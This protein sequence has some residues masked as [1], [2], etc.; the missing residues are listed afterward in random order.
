MGLLETAVPTIVICTRDRER[1]T[2]FYRDALGLT[3]AYADSFASV[4]NSGGITLRVSSVTDFVPHGHTILG[5][6]VADVKQS[7]KAL[8]ANGVS[9]NTYPGFSQDDLGI[10]TLPSGTQ[11][12]WFN[13][14]D[15]NV[16][17]VTNA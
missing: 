9:F 8:R 12:A 5:F 1:S 7:V 13:D 16:L 6:R 11:V 17:S 4:F 2:E 10:L 15:G 14:P 3:F